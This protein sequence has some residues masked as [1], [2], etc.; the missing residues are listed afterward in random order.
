MFAGNRM[1]NCPLGQHL[2]RWAVVATC[3][4]WWPTAVPAQ[5]PATL[6]PRN[7]V[8]PTGSA[9][10]DLEHVGRG[11]SLAGEVQRS[12]V[13]TG[14]FGDGADFVS[15]E[16]VCPPG[17]AKPHDCEAAAKQLCRQHG[18]TD[19]SSFDQVGGKICKQY[20]GVLGSSDARKCKMKFWITKAVC[21][22]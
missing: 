14:I 11:G 5:I 19:G 3:V 1:T 15:G 16:V 4:L 7:F 9:E 10:P 18:Y 8:V 17:D 22:R 12:G 2:A 6:N 21:W 20:F 13:L